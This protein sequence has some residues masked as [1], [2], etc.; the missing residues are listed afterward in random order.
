[1]IKQDVKDVIL[2]GDDEWTVLELSTLLCCSVSRMHVIVNQLL[3]EG[4]I[5]CTGGGRRRKIV[6]RNRAP[7]DHSLKLT[8]INHPGVGFDKLLELTRSSAAD[9]YRIMYDLNIAPDLKPAE[10]VG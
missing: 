6:S 7:I 3:D 1:M 8:V 5:V 2:A 4:V 10:C 9:L